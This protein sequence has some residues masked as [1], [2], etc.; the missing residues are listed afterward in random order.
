M[1]K[2]LLLYKEFLQ[3]ILSLPGQIWIL[4]MGALYYEQA[5]GPQG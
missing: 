1:Y 3:Q 4:F 5:A 2:N